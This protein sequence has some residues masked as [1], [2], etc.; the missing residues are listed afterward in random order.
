[1]E[2]AALM[3]NQWML[4]R[5][6]FH[7]YINANC[8]LPLCADHFCFMKVFII[9]YPETPEIHLPTPLLNSTLFLRH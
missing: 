4:S 8:K 2:V 9:V 1:M 7:D 3:L 6:I 5:P